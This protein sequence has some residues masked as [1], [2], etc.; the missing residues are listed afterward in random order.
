MR[1]REKIAE[2]E[3]VPREISY[4]IGHSRVSLCVLL[5]QKSIQMGTNRDFCHFLRL[6]A[7]F[8]QKTRDA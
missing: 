7:T 1:P 8:L 4:R 2:T 5:A 3:N 6:L